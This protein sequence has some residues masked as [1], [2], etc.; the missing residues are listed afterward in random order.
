MIFD[1][2][3][4]K[5]YESTDLNPTWDG[6]YQNKKLLPA[7]YVYMIKGVC[8]DGEQVIFANDITLIR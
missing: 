8:K 4:N 6:T 1:R 5:L 3:G 7:V 2:W